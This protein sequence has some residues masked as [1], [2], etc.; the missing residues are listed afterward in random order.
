L[1]VEPVRNVIGLSKVVSVMSKAIQQHEIENFFN[2]YEARFNDALAGGEPDIDETINSFAP[3]FIEANPAG[4]IAGKNDK[5][6]KKSISEGWMFYKK[7]GIRSMD[8]LSNQI[9]ILDDFHAIV[10]IHWNSSFVRKDKSKGDI[11]FD[12]Y[13]LVQ[14]NKDDI[15]IFAYITGDEQQ[16]LKDEGLIS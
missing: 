6:F 1:L 13:Y 15:R 4:V 10:K 7:I 2:G 11:A 8:I 16:A 12:V 14:K 9:T 3:Y 5:K